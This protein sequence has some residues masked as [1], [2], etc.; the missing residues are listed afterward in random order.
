MRISSLT[1]SVVARISPAGYSL[2]L[3]VLLAAGCAGNVHAGDTASIATSIKISPL[4]AVAARELQSGAGANPLNGLVRSDARGRIQVYVYVDD[5]SAGAV[6][7]L[8]ANGLQN[9]LVNPAMHIAQGWVKPQNLDKLA[10]LSFVTRI[11]P[12]H[13]AR[14][15]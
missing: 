11:T 13:Y 6:S 14:P 8:G 1:D 15:R 7:T 4:L 3:A 12:P 9:M 5:T 10:A 2:L